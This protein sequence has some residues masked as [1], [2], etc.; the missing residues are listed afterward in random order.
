[1]QSQSRN[2]PTQQHYSGFTLIELLVV[3]SII[4]LLIGILLPAL[5]NARKAARGVQCATQLRQ[6]GYA[7]FT[8][9]EDFKW[10]TTPRLTGTMYPYNS[11]DWWMTLR[12]YLAYDHAVP[13]NW[14]P[15]Q[16]TCDTGVLACPEWNKLGTDHKSYAQN[17]LSYL[18]DPTNSPKYELGPSQKWH[19]SQPD[20]TV[21]PDSQ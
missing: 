7:Q 16:N 14:K 4:S 11:G 2:H 1:M 8:Y 9:A 18:C 21:R 15:Y 6:I 17:K 5:A 3:I 20:Y 19:P 13:T 10:F 12:S